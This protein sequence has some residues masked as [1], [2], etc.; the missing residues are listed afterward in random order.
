MGVCNHSARIAVSKNRQT[1]DNLIHCQH[2]YDVNYDRADHIEDQVDRRRPLCVLLTAQ[3]SQQ[4]GGTGADITAENNEHAD[5]HAHQPLIGQKHHD[6][7]RHG[8]ALNHCRQY[9]PQKNR[10]KRG[11]QRSKHM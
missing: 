3:G 2:K 6:T 5:I 11:L 7:D 1:A 9:C 4:R 8:R 10:Q